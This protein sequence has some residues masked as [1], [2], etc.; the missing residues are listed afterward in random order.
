[1]SGKATNNAVVSR[2]TA[3]AATLAI[4][5]VRRACSDEGGGDTTAAWVIEFNY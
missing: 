5:S 1:M 3:N 4:S 2:K